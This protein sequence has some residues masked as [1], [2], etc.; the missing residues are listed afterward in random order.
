MNLRQIT[1]VWVCLAILA[2]T[3][4]KSHADDAQR[5]QAWVE[6]L[7]AD[8]MEGRGP[9]TAGIDL[10]R[11][12]LVEQFE[13]MRHTGVQPGFGDSFLQAFE[14]DLGVE[15]TRRSL[16]IGEHEAKPDVD[17]SVM[18]F[19][20][21]GAF[22]GE[23]VFVGYGIVEPKRS[24]DSFAQAEEVGGIKGKVVV[25]F[26]YEPMDGL[27]ESRW[28]DRAAWS[29][30][31]NLTRKAAWAAE[32]GAVALVLVNP[33]GM[34]STN[35]LRPT[36]RTAFESVADIPVVHVSSLWLT[37]A[38]KGGPIDDGRTF[39]RE[40]QHRA[41]HGRDR[42]TALGVTIRGDIAVER[43]RATL[44]NV[45]AALPGRGELAHEWVIIGAHYD[46]LGYGDPGSLAQT[47]GIHPGADDNA[48]GVAGVLLLAHRFAGRDMA[49]R[50]VE[51]VDQAPTLPRRSLLFVLFSGEERGLLGSMHF[52]RHMHELDLHA[53]R[54]AA[55]I[56]LD[57][58][59]RLRDRKLHVF[60][61]ATGQGLGD[62]VK[63]AAREHKL[64]LT[65]SGSGL[66]MSD[67][68]AFYFKRIP[69]VHF[70]TGNHEDYH[71]PSDTADRIN[72]AGIVQV[73]DA[74][75]SVAL[76]LSRATLRMAF[77]EAPDAHAGPGMMARGAGGAF[78]G[79]MP[80][81]ATLEGDDGCGI[82]GVVPRS[83]AAVAGLREGDRI[84]A[85]NE[86]PVANVHDLTTH[87]ARAKP[88]DEVRLSVLRDG[89]TL[90]ITVTLAAR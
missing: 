1:A 71:R 67:H 83:P 46:H 23:A 45:A 14:A 2:W 59:G 66:G 50:Y 52:T 70:F 76:Q 65:T 3:G 30:A 28:A 49:E 36:A 33:P 27:G 81:Y 25:A 39:L 22:E 35:Q 53:D 68:T 10:A 88:R 40:M 7:T 63:A 47:R 9:G 6:T 89:Q 73:T 82:G 12:W 64:Q 43:R 55:M 74:V 84:T 11:D 13:A 19:S 48:S 18:G 78:L 75:E 87:L 5:V 86:A 8:E 60:G 42:P 16:A 21:N 26:R 24:Y 62:V 58:I 41:D 4:P 57:M 37:E 90:T 69:A 77:V 79:V 32:R 44:H 31:A 15:A 72:A 54:V 20:A 34:D 80:D 85:W 29:E 17:V 56:N 51:Q 61:V 38:I